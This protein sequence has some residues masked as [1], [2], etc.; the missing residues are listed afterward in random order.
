MSIITGQVIVWSLTLRGVFTVGVM[1]V[2]D[3][4]I[5]KGALELASK[6]L[7]DYFYMH[8]FIQYIWNNGTVWARTCNWGW[9]NTF[10]NIKRRIVEDNSWHWFQIFSGK[11]NP[12][13]F[14]TSN[15]FSSHIDL[16]VLLYA[17]RSLFQRG[18]SQDPRPLWL[19]LLMERFELLML[20]TQRPFF[21]AQ[22]KFRLV[23]GTGSLISPFFFC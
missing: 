19:F 8:A 17:F 23:K 21:F 7:L 18:F 14:T 4:H 6:F 3:G 20:V 15:W 2:F 1:A 13:T 16:Y 22:R 10:G 9:N 5:G 11:Q 12:F